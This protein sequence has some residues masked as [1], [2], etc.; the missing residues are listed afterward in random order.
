MRTHRLGFAFNGGLFK[1]AAM[2]TIETPTLARH[3]DPVI[4]DYLAKKIQ[5]EFTSRWDDLWGGRSLLHGRTPSSN[6]VRL[7]GNDYLNLTGHADIVRAQTVAMKNDADFVIQSSVFLHGLHPVREL[8]RSLADWLGK[9]DGM[10]CQSGYAANAL[11]TL[12]F[13]RVHGQLV[14]QPTRSGTTTQRI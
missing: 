2:Q 7:N 3:L 9:E 13:G 14:H 5:R 6:A 10:I 8:E 11:L 1:K 12:H 4:S